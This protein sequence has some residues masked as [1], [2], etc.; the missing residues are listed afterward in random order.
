ML[1]VG[2]FEINDMS[3]FDKYKSHLD[4]ELPESCNYL[5][6][7]TI[8]EIKNFVLDSCKCVVYEYPY[9]DKDFLSNYYEHYSYKFN[10]VDKRSLR[11]LFFSDKT[12][13]QLIGYVTLYNLITENHIGRMFFNPKY[14][15]EKK[16]ANYILSK[17]KIHLAGIEYNLDCFPS[18]GSIEPYVCGHSAIWG[19]VRHRGR[20]YEYSAKT[21]GE[22]NKSTPFEGNREKYF[23][24]I[25]LKQ[26][27]K[28]LFD[29]GFAPIERI[30]NLHTSK[31]QILK[32]VG[33]AIESKMPVI[34]I[35]DKY[36]HAVV[37]VGYSEFFKATQVERLKG[38]CK[39]FNFYIEKIK[40]D[41]QTNLSL[42]QAADLLKSIF[43]N[44]NNRLP[45][46]E[47]KTND[48]IHNMN[49]TQIQHND[50]GSK[51]DET[52]QNYNMNDISAAVFPFYSRINLNY[53]ETEL[54]VKAEIKK[55]GKDIGWIR[56][57]KDNNL[58]TRI[59][60]T[61]SNTYREY[62]LNEMMFCDIETLEYHIYNKIKNVEFP[63]FIW[64]AEIA[65]Y[66]EFDKKNVS[67]LILFDTTASIKDENAKL[68][69]LGE[70]YM[71]YR[72][73]NNSEIVEFKENKHDS[74]K[75]ATPLL[76]RFSNN[77]D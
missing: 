47:L 69:V 8:N 44:D 48:F 57:G 45:Y 1:K 63:R 3:D 26:I 74:L 18:I 17:Y 58:V 42:I 68:F 30:Q 75:N 22:I 27:S 67:G 34:L 5:N 19:V 40:I 31:R 28:V 61:S 51:D 35:V 25:T 23:D 56:E 60:M 9:Y 14:L 43:V 33:V 71:K 62:A 16:D 29:L 49:S 39:D 55:N 59:F 32:E 46:Y 53:I 41:E 12:C 37:G 76:N 20:W 11:L 38:T 52:L 6:E 24:G 66:E 21:T 7:N 15:K 36:N 72:N 77:F 2:K 13:T 73:Y 50:I 70:K 10:P 54:L 64:V 4:S 65:T